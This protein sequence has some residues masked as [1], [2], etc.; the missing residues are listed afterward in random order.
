MDR[1]NASC[2]PVKRQRTWSAVAA[3]TLATSVTGL[4]WQLGP[5]EQAGA[6][7]TL[8]ATHEQRLWA[9][10]VAGALGHRRLTDSDYARA[11]IS[12]LDSQTG[13]EV[14]LEQVRAEMS[15]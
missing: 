14:L 15:C 5:P 2:P 13:S 7:P 12:R 6:A 8:H 3:L 10:E 1:S 11:G 4:L 9:A